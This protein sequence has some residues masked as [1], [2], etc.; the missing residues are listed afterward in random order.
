M[1]PINTRNRKPDSVRSETGLVGAVIALNDSCEVLEKISDE[2]PVLRGNTQVGRLLAEAIELNHKACDI[3]ENVSMREPKPS[4]DSLKRATVF[5]HKG[6]PPREDVYL[7]DDGSVDGNRLYVLAKDVGPWECGTAKCSACP[8]GE[9]NPKAQR[10]TCL[11]YYLVRQ[12]KDLVRDEFAAGVPYSKD[13][14]D[15]FGKRDLVTIAKVVG[16]NQFKLKNTSHGGLVGLI[17]AAQSDL[18]QESTHG[19]GNRT[20]TSSGETPRTSA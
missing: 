7:S 13:Q 10:K 11:D 9:G 15:A 8:Y 1:K 18:E 5:D 12:A 17:L 6:S 3:V 19:P 2:F 16:V 4:V 14:L 20:A